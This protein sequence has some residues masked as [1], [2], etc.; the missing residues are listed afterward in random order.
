MPLFDK[1]IFRALPDVGKWATLQC[2][3]LSGQRDN[4]RAGF[5]VRELPMSSRYICDDADLNICLTKFI[6]REVNLGAGRACLHGDN[7]PNFTC[8]SVTQ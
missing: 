2:E 5:G 8:T 1:G 6:N 3:F 7:R 4:R